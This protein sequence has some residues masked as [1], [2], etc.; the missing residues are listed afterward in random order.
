[1]DGEE[2]G[3]SL[4]DLSTN[5]REIFRRNSMYLIYLGAFCLVIAFSENTEVG[6][7]PSA[8]LLT[9]ATLGFSLLG[10]GFFLVGNNRRVVDAPRWMLFFCGGSFIAYSLVFY[11]A[12]IS[13]GTTDEYSWPRTQSLLI[14]PALSFVIVYFLS[15]KFNF[16]FTQSPTTEKKLPLSLLIIKWGSYFCTCFWVW[17]IILCCSMLTKGYLQGTYLVF[18]MISAVFASTNFYYAKYFSTKREADS[19]NRR[20]FHWI[21]WPIINLSIVLLLLSLPW[22]AA[23]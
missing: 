17:W 1:M 3:G 21:G 5:N 23:A 7:Q 9:L 8:F 10:T 2:G 12:L 6:Q 4:A 15:R 11:M 14:F 18:I 19:T 22:T 20:F 13:S 16:N